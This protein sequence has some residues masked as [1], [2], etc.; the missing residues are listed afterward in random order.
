MKPRRTTNRARICIAA[1][2]A[3]A[4]TVHA[5]DEFKPVWDGKTLTGWHAIGKGQWKIEEGAIH[6]VHLKSD[7]GYG[8][9]VSD[10]NYTN[11]TIRLKFK[12]LEGNSGLYFRSEEKGWGGISG[13]QAEIDAKADVGGLYETNG[14]GWVAKPKA[15]DVRRWFKPGEWNEIIVTAVGRHVT[16]HVNGHKSAELRNDTHGRAHGKIALQL[17]GGQE[18][19]VWLKDIEIAER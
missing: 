11:F 5:A 16:V 12:S 17:H 3:I 18:V 13:F 9:L 14:R 4:L 1:S 10:R 19:D 6:G 7:P 15:A 2:L 8:H